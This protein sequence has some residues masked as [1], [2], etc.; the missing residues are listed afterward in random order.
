MQLGTDGQIRIPPEYQRKLGWKPGD[1]VELR[2]SQG[3]LIVQLPQTASSSGDLI[4][5][6]RGKGR[7]KM[8][9]AEVM[10]LLRDEG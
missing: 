1:E 8:R 6:M 5:A 2:V 3:A 9:T 10:R 4:K 7:L